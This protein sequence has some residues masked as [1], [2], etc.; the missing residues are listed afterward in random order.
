MVPRDEAER[1]ARRFRIPLWRKQHLFLALALVLGYVI[2]KSITLL[3]VVP[4]VFRPAGATTAIN[5]ETG[6]NAWA[7]VRRSP[8]STAY[9]ADPAPFPRTVKW[10]FATAKPLISS[11]AVVAD[12]VY[13]TTEDGRTLAL[14]RQTGKVVWE[15]RSGW[16]SSSTPAVTPDLVISAVRPGM[17]VA[18]DRA[19]GAVRWERD[20]DSPILSSPVVVDG[21]IYLGTAESQLYA[22]DAATGRPRWSFPTGAWVI[23]PVAYSDGTVAVAAQDSRMLIVGADTG[24]RQLLFDSGR[25]RRISGGPVIQGDMVYFGTHDGSVWGID[26]H[27]RTYP[28]GRTIL[29]WQTSLYIW[30][31]GPQPVQKGSVWSTRIGG[32]LLHTPAVTPDTVYAVNKQGKVAALDA[33][34]GEERWSTQVDTDITSAPTVAGGTVLVGTWDGRVLGLDASNGERLWEFKTGGKI[35]ASPVVAGDTIYVASND[36][37]LYALTA[38]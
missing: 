11:P 23:A 36:G 38:R 19:T 21:T 31:I 5:A 25:S 26:R 34:T 29:Y 3:D 1:R 2:W 14:E 22:L 6:P 18:L 12:R 35:T 8:R 28:F 37:I 16:P 27:A 17:L 20:M 9:T 24:R 4:L 7:Q 32:D 13:L 15:Y 10:T 33:A 30:G